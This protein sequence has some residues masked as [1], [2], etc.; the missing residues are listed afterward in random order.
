MRSS[1]A[2]VDRALA[3]SQALGATVAAPV[4]AICLKDSPSAL[5]GGQPLFQPDN[6]TFL[7]LGLYHDPAISEL[8]WWEKERSTMGDRLLRHINTRNSPIGL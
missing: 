8:D 7:I 1:K 6:G 4:P 2:I 3:I 5:A